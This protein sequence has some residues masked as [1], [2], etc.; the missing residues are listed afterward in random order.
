[1]NPDG[2]THSSE[3]IDQFEKLLKG[4]PADVSDSM[5]VG[6]SGP[7]VMVDTSKGGVGNDVNGDV[8]QGS[9]GGGV[10]RPL[11]RSGEASDDSYA[12]SIAPSIH[13]KEEARFSSPQNVEDAQIA[14]GSHVSTRGTKRVA[15]EQLEP[16]PESLDVGESRKRPLENDGDMLDSVGVCVTDDCSRVHGIM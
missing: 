16:E 3:C 2:L 4:S 8:A 1:M 13:E 10:K 11:E 12:P 5:K 15:D 7:S 14:D 9:F 6:T